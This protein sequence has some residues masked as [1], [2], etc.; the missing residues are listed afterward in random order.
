MP[1][2]SLP[3]TPLPPSPATSVTPAN[4][5]K[6]L[7]DCYQRAA[8]SA[9]GMS[10]LGQREG[11]ATT[12]YGYER[13][14]ADAARYAGRLRLRGVG[15]GDAVLVVLPTGHEF[16]VALIALQIL[17][18]IPVPAYPPAALQ[19]LESALSRL[20][21]IARHSRAVGIITDRHISPLIGSLALSNTHLAFIESAVYPIATSLPM[22]APTDA[23]MNP[24][25]PAFMQYTSGSTAK[26]KGVVIPH[27]AALANL[28]AIGGAVQIAEGDVVGHWLP[29]YHDMGLLSMLAGFAWSRPVVLLSPMSFLLEPWRWLR[30][31]HDHRITASVA[32]NMGYALCS[33]RCRA[34]HLDGIDLTHWR[35]SLCGAEPVRRHTMEAF[36]RQFVRY[37]L[38]REILMPCYG[39]AENT[40]AV[41]IF[42]RHRA[43]H[44]DVIHRATSARDGIVCRPE[45]DIDVDVDVDELGQDADAAWM[46]VACVGEAI[47]DHA[48]RIVD[49]SGHPLP[50]D[51]IG[52]IEVKGP[53]NMAGYF[54]DEAATRAALRNGWLRTGDLGYLRHNQLY[55]T[56]RIKDLL[57]ILGRNYHAEDIEEQVEHLDGV[58]AGGAV[59]F[60]VEDRQSGSERPVIVC[61]TALAE[62]HHGDTNGDPD[63]T[64]SDAGEARAA[65]IERIATCVG[66]FVGTRPADVV[67]LTRGTIPKTSSGKRQRSEARA[68]YLDGALTG[69]RHWARPFISAM[70][71]SGI[72]HLLTRARKRRRPPTREH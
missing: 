54:D 69:R 62:P 2:T 3:P 26:P 65:L 44:Y 59:A 11:D 41:T 68:R 4:Q 60:A 19:R 34:E 5:P 21:H 72:G 37:G 20:D 39:L 7:V 33:R 18:A 47:A 66:E 50:E 49:A 45:P 28:H 53:S 58:R 1:P 12:S 35:V 31:I 43:P 14:W 29:L 8:R 52:E 70:A 30:M 27:R 67:L 22:V 23:A 17:A 32:P 42:D 38:R 16:V 6:T 36:Y 57:I 15:P 64:N 9:H 61:E 25:T 13:L 63:G 51:C 55:V 24:E 71:K 56:G 48:I 40:L 46:S 10:V